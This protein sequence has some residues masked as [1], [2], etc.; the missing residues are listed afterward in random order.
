MVINSHHQL[1]VFLEPI[2]AMLQ[3]TPRARIEDHRHVTICA[4]Y[5]QAMINETN[6]AFQREATDRS[7]HWSRQNRVN[8]RAQGAKRPRQS[9]YRTHGV[10]IWL[11]MRRKERPLCRA[12]T[13]NKRSMSNRG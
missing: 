13:G 9:E 5:R 10:T 12:K 7:I 2:T 6:L 11:E 4:W 8:R 1:R 3:L